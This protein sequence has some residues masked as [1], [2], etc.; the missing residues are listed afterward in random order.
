M[1]PPTTA[2][3]DGVK[4]GTEGKALRRASMT[5]TV[6][7]TLEMEALEQRALEQRQAKHKWLILPNSL[8]L[9][10]WLAIIGPLI[11]YNVIW[12]PLEVSQMA[13]PDC[14]HS[15]FDFIL[16]FFFYID[17]IINF[18]TAY[19]NKESELVLDGKAIA[20]RY[21][22]GHFWVDFVATVQLE[23]FVTGMTAF[24]CS[25]SGSSDTEAVAAFSILRLPRLLRLLRLFKKLDMFPSLN[26]VKVRTRNDHARHPVPPSQSLAV[27]RLVSSYARRASPVLISLLLPSSRASHRSSFSC[28]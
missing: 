25:D 28:L 4:F 6:L 14:L 20:R 27:P 23:L 3:G 19:V 1:A 12:V 18:R 8:F 5:R 7:D 22:S 2:M 11:V 10:V 26:V 13:R 9:K 16:D 17:I 24:K 21:L 15:D